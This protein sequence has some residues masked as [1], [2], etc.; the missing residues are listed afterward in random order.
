[1][2]SL[3]WPD[4]PTISA[5][6]VDDPPLAGSAVEAELGQAGEG[7]HRGRGIGYRYGHPAIGERGWKQVSDLARV[8]AVRPGELDERRPVVPGDEPE[9]SPVGDPLSGQHVQGQ[10]GGDQGRRRY[11]AAGMSR[12]IVHLVILPVM[13]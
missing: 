7:F 4:L 13:T 1:M 12:P 5:V 2:T 6:F 11:V 9:R 8:V 10:P 3:A